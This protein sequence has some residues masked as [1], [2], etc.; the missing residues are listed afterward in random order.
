MYRHTWP[1]IKLD[2]DVWLGA[3]IPYTAYRH[4][5]SVIKLDINVR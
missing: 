3:C 4:T 2:I 1:F 5:W